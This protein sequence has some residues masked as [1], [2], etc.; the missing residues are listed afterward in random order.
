MIPEKLLQLLKAADTASLDLAMTICKTEY[1]AIWAL[2]ANLNV[3]SSDVKDRGEAVTAALRNV[4]INI[5]DVVKYRG[6]DTSPTMVVTNVDMKKNTVMGT[7]EYFTT[8]ITCK[9]YNK[10]S[11]GFSNVI[12]RI[13]CFDKQINK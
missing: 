8:M 4:H 6:I 2:L 13:E 9:Y 12:D 5:G 7:Y 3:N 11:Q 10:S 1:P